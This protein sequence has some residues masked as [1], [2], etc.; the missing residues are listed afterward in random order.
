M[1]GDGAFDGRADFALPVFW[2]RASNP[3]AGFF[4]EGDLQANEGR[5]PASAQPIFIKA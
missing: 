5:R 2:I 3:F 1:L 4:V